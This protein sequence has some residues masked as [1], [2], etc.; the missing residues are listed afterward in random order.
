MKDP[1]V[2]DARRRGWPLSWDAVKR[3]QLN[4]E[5]EELHPYM[6]PKIPVFEVKPVQKWGTAAMYKFCEREVVRA[7]HP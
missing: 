6:E 1:A 5:D 2:L 7:L 4:R 3:A